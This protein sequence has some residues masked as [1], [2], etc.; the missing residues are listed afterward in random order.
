MCD[1]CEKCGKFAGVVLLLA[2]V[3]FLLVDL[4]VWTFWNVKWYTILILLGGLVM[5]GSNCCPEC[6]L[7]ERYL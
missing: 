3:G 2:G 1:L 6:K 5:L 4:G 7:P